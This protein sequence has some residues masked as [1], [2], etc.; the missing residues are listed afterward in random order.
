LEAEKIRNLKAEMKAT[1]GLRYQA[2]VY[3]F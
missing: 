1:T 2:N 3:G